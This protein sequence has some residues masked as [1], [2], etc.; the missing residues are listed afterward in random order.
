MHVELRYLVSEGRDIELVACGKRLERAR[1]RR[2]FA[3]ELYLRVLLEIDE[4][5]ETGQSRDKDQPRIIGVARQQHTGQRQV[6]DRNR[7]QNELRMQRPVL[8]K[9]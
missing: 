5:D 4:L 8:R 2:D 1:G 7:V 9:P 3:N 6:A